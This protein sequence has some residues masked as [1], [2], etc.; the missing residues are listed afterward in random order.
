MEKVDLLKITIIC[1]KYY[2][3]IKKLE[4]EFKVTRKGDICIAVGGD[5]T[6]VKAAREFNGPILAIR[7]NE[8]N[9]SGYYSDVSVKDMELIIKKLKK[10]QYSVE[11]LG[12]KIALSYKG[13]KYYAVNE[14]LLHNWRE[15]VYFSIYYKEDHAEKVVYPYIMAGDGVLVTSEVGSTA[16]NRSAGGPII[17]SPRLLCVTFLNADGPYTNSIILSPDKTLGI[18][19]EK[20]RGIIRYDGIDVGT[21]HKKEYFEVSLSRKELKVIRLNGMREDTATKLSRIIKGRMRRPEGIE[22]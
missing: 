1:K 3:E 13:K 4:K 19:I 12:N 6:F 21:I 11:S 9:S 18:R 22:Y 7:G 8:S 5:G 20:Y 14:I 16:Y 17:L 15:E 2:K 10:K